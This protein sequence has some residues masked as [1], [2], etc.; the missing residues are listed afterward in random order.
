MRSL[1]KLTILR[2]SKLKRYAVLLHY[3]MTELSTSTGRSSESAT[4]DRIVGAMKR[5]AYDNRF[6]MPTNR[7]VIVI[8]TFCASFV[9]RV[10]AADPQESEVRTAQDAFAHL[11]GGARRTLHGQGACTRFYLG[12]SDGNRGRPGHFP[13]RNYGRYDYWS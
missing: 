2:T 1:L 3:L 7:R 11:L 6:N 5:V 12:F 8:L 9:A 10:W 4:T 13:R